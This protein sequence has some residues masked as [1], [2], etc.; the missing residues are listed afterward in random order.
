MLNPFELIAS[1]S[2]HQVRR[3]LV[4]MDLWSL[5]HGHGD[6]LDIAPELFV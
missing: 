3:D 5:L 4:N 6:L 1:T 2:L